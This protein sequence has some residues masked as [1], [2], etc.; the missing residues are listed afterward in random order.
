MVKA[1]S[2]FLASL[3]F[4]ASCSNIEGRPKDA[5]SLKT[6]SFVDP[7]K[8]VGLWCEIARYPN[9]FEKNCINVTAQYEI[10]PDNKI[11]VL[12]SCVDAN[13][14]VKKSAKAK[15]SI[16]E[17]SNNAALAVN[18]APFPLPKGKGNYQ[19]LYIGD[20]YSSALVGS[21]SGKYLWIL[22]RTPKI[23]DSELYKILSVAK[24]NQFDTKKLEYVEQE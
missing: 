15:A 22:S 19:I 16:I 17:G 12:N 6:V 2:I 3:A 13:T 5:P 8:Y 4:L 14:K 10:L 7:Q 18:F 23:D 9:S 11:G 20:N 24:A 21:P 1:N